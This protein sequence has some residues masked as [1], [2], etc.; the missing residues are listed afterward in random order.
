LDAKAVTPDAAADLI[1][2]L[3]SGEADSLSGHFFSVDE[4]A[5]EIAPQALAVREKKLYLLRGR[6]L[7][8]ARDGGTGE[9]QAQDAAAV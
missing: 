8:E 7:D 4:N 3:A 6:T 1:L 2:F 9:I 5:K